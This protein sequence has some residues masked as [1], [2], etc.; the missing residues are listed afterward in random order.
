MTQSTLIRA[1]WMVALLVVLAAASA[2]A[3]ARKGAG[4]GMPRYDTS[5]EMTLKGTVDEVQ[6]HQARS[7]G[8]GTHLVFKTESSVMDVHVGPSNWLAEKKYEFAKGDSLEIVGSKV[9]VEGK[10]AFL[11]REIRKDGVTMTL[12]DASGKPV[13]SGGPKP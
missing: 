8:T 9:T 10:D 2:P 4:Q 11:A 1:A 3:Q 12:R 6:P 13:W 7:G 5:T